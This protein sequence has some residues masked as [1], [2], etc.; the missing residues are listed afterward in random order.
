MRVACLFK[1]LHNIQ[2]NIV[3]S[4][5]FTKEVVDAGRFYNKKTKSTEGLQTFMIY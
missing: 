3:I 2:I 1:W 5:S 4:F